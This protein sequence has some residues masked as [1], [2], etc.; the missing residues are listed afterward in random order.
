MSGERRCGTCGGAEDFPADPE[1]E[2]RPYGPGGSLICYGCAFGS[3]EAEAT[4]KRSMTALFEASAATSPEGGIV[5][6]DDDPQP[7]AAGALDGLSTYTFTCPDCGG[8]APIFAA[9]DPVDAAEQH[10][11]FEAA[12]AIHRRTGCDAAPA[13]RGVDDQREQR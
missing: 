13:S 10:D 6:T 8:E 11:M 3:P 5:L 2:L 9:N 1:S 12:V 7:L 4:T